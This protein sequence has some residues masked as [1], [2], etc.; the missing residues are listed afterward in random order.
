MLLVQ[1]NRE[2]IAE[3]KRSGELLVLDSASDLPTTRRAPL[4]LLP[5]L[6]SLRDG[7]RKAGT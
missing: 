1:G 4:A 6:A 2:Q 7:V 3:L 5:S